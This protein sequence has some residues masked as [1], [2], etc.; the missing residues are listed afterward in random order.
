M[1]DKN[2]IVMIDWWQYVLIAL[3]EVDAIGKIKLSNQYIVNCH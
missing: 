1:A 3:N 2:I